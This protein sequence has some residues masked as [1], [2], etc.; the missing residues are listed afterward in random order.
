[1][2]PPARARTDEPPAALIDGD[3]HWARRSALLAQDLDV[4]ATREVTAWSKG[5]RSDAAGEP[6]LLSAYG[7]AGA[8][9]RAR[10][11][12]TRLARAGR[13]T[14]DESLAYD[15][16]LAYWPHVQRAAATDRVDPLFVLAMMRQE[17]LF[18][19]EAV[20]P[21]GARGLMQLM[22]GTAARLAPG[23]L[24]LRALADP[25]TSIA[26]GT[27]ELG[28]LLARYGGDVAKAA[29]AYNAGEAAVDKWLARDPG[30]EPDVFVE[31]IGYRETRKYVKAVLANLRRYRRLY[32]GHEA[33][34]ESSPLNRP[35]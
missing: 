19:P 28:R 32:P 17:S 6:F 31:T 5:L 34:G 14:T 10:A 18:D 13:I 29:A 12:A 21:V 20:S 3:Y 9:A 26:L 4:L 30:L 24:D 16:P 8:H 11:L 22:P 1:L 33:A 23:P 27:R 15:Y 35:G 2:P 25:A 7:S